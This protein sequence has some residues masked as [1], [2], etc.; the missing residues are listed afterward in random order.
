[1]IIKI[2]RK[3]HKSMLEQKGPWR[4]IG[5]IKEKPFLWEVV[6]LFLA[7]KTTSRLIGSLFDRSRTRIEIAI[8]YLCNLQCV[9][10]DNLCRQAPSSEHMSAEQVGKFIKESIENKAAWETIRILGGE[11]TL[12]PNISE[13]VQL[14]LKYKKDYAPNCKVTLVTNGFGEKV[15]KILSILPKEL[16]IENTAKKSPFQYFVAFNM[17]PCDLNRF[18][19]AD[20]SV[21]CGIMSGCGMGLTPFGYYPCVVAGAIDRVLGFNLGRKKLPRND[22]SMRDQLKVF[23]RY[24]GHLMTRMTNKEIMTPTWVDACK[25]YRIKK[26]ELSRY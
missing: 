17:A 24:C 12:H 16:F 22:D 21:G 11:P 5:F 26:P 4:I 10:C 14:L 20:Y 15:N 25:R 3:I 19:F 9:N 18:Q 1:M 13:I 23:C 2:P 6:K 8:T 7:Q